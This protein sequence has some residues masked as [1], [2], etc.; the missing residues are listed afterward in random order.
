M[1]QYVLDNKVAFC[2]KNNFFVW[3]KGIFVTKI[4]EN[5][6]ADGILKTGDQIISVNGEDLTNIEHEGAVFLLKSCSKIA[7]LIVKRY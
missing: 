6:P 3:L 1:I 5:G 2:T 7:N 4:Q